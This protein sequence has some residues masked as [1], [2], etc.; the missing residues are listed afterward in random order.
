MKD[1]L[2]KIALTNRKNI[3][4]KKELDQNIL[5]NLQ[6]LKIIKQTKNI[7][8][9]LSFGTEIDTY[10][11]INYFQDKNFY[12]P[13]IE[14]NEMNF[15]KID[16]FYK[17]NKFNIKE[18]TSNLKINDLKN[19]VIIV[20]GLMFDKRLNRLGYGKGYYDKYLKDKNIYK[21]GLCYSC[22]L[23][24]NLEIEEHDIKMDL[25]ITEER[26]SFQD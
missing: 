6:E 16:G 19:S 21:I 11:I 17:L 15:Y 18:P 23:V 12:A 24:D 14:N 9:Y 7:L 22:N 5:L 20:P 3:K 1:K 2:R 10:N 26:W 4:N 13:R 8:I 25:V